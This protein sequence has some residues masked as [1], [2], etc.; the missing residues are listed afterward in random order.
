MLANTD[1]DRQVA[2]ALEIRL[3]GPAREGGQQETEDEAGKHLVL[4]DEGMQPAR[5]R[6][7]LRHRQHRRP[8]CGGQPCCPPEHR[9]QQVAGADEEH[10]PVRRSGQQAR[11]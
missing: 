5:I 1:A 6:R 4:H 8:A 10:Q 3:A 9:Q 11:R 2:P 7:G